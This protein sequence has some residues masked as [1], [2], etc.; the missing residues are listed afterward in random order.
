MEVMVNGEPILTISAPRGAVRTTHHA[1][2]MARG[3]VETVSVRTMVLSEIE[4]VSIEGPSMTVTVTRQG[5]DLT[6]H[7]VA[8]R[9]LH[10][11][12]HGIVGRTMQDQR[13]LSNLLQQTVLTAAEDYEVHGPFGSDFDG[14]AFQNVGVLL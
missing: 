8:P 10:G 5:A 7:M 14:N 2:D 3:V 13:P 9:G 1:A 6:M 4:V 11:N 12:V